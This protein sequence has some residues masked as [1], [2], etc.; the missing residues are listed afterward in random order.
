VLTLSW[1][2]AATL[3]LVLVGLTLTRL[4]TWYLGIDQ[5]GYLT[6]ARDLLAGR[7]AHHW[8]PADALA[9]RLPERTDVLGQT[10]VWDRGQLYCRYAPG[11][12]ILLAVW[13]ALFG[14]R[15]A[16]YLN[17]LLYVALIG[18][19]IVLHLRL[20]GSRWRALAGGMLFVLFPTATHLWGVTLTRDVAAHLAAFAGL[21]LALPRPVL[22]PWRGAAAG[23]ALGFAASIRPD[24]VL[25]LL[26]AALL[27]ATQWRSVT[28]TGR[29]LAAILLGLGVGL[30]P[31]LGYNWLVNGNPLIP[32][33][34]MEIEEFLAAAPR[35]HPVVLAQAGGAD[36]PVGFA[37]P[38]WRG[39]T[40]TP[41]QGGGLRLSNLPE[42]LP[43]NVDLLRR[44]YGWLFLALA[45]CGAALALGENRPLFLAAVPYTVAA[46]LFYSCWGRPDSSRYLFGLHALLPMLILQAMA[47]TLGLCER[48]AARSP[49]NA[50]ALAAAVSV[51]CLLGAALAPV[52]PA[53]GALPRIT[54][55]V[56]G[57]TAAG[58]LVLVVRPGLRVTEI[59]AVVLTLALAVVLVGRVSGG[60]GRRA[61]FQ[62]A[63]M[64]QA[65]ANV[66]RVLAPS[67]V[68]I[69]SEELG[70]PAENIEYYT[71]AHA[72]YLTDL[73]RWHL[74]VNVVARLLFAAGLQ[75][76]LLLAADEPAT[77]RLTRALDLWFELRLV[78]DIPPAAGFD[79]FATAGFQRRTRMGLWAIERRRPE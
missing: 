4:I 66:E 58:A 73:E 23:L 79:W 25:Y 48:L 76:Y 39:G 67:S 3:L 56:P 57:L 15:A 49:A 78:T 6:F 63:Q 2:L 52:P 5:F 46:L 43:K 71:A 35:T 70:R 19:L 8:P 30:A 16:H 28:A 50:R 31:S 11:F 75:P 54:L 59:T 26:P 13:I 42:T 40:M 29:P 22:A 53:S 51:I 17:P 1:W 68:V 10:Y 20:T 60:L 45:A 55:L 7:I 21:L 64:A 18:V 34:G 69:T 74:P 44:A 12:P 61:P 38:A 47:V 77:L 24:A 72:L 65:R 62:E 37:P 36:R 14:E 33:Q 9:V 41:V 27:L 32:T